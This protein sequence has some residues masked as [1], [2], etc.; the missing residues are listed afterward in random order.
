VETIFP[1][2]AEATMYTYGLK[3]L[4]VAGTRFSKDVEVSVPMAELA[5][6][7]AGISAE[8]HSHKLFVKVYGNIGSQ[9]NGF[10]GFWHLSLEL[11][12]MFLSRVNRH[13]AGGA[14][15]DAMIDFVGLYMKRAAKVPVIPMAEEVREMLAAAFKKNS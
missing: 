2:L 9:I 12:T 7:A 6:W 3:K 13:G 8:I 5:R 11:A 15:L 1:Q 14:E 4:V 10:P